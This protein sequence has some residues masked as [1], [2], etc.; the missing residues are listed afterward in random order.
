MPFVVI[1]DKALGPLDVG[2]LD[3]V[4][5]V[6]EPYSIAHLIEQPLWVVVSCE[7]PETWICSRSR[8]AIQCR[9]VL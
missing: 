4:C 6:P 9:L 1:E 7:S 3:T 8:A 5:I 2:L